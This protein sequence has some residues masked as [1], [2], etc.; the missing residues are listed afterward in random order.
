MWKLHPKRDAQRKPTKVKAYL[1]NISATAKYTTKLSLNFLLKIF[2][3]FPE[4]IKKNKVPMLTTILIPEDIKII[5]EPMMTSIL[6][7]KDNFNFT[8]HSRAYS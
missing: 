2:H 5:K 8:N 6:V 4:N 3:S 1:Y 7:A